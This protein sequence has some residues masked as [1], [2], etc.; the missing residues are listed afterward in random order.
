MPSTNRGAGPEDVKAFRWSEERRSEDPPEQ[1][2]RR[3]KPRECELHKAPARMMESEHRPRLYLQMV[4]RSNRFSK[5]KRPVVTGYQE[6]LAIVDDIPRCG[7][8]EGRGTPPQRGALF[9]KED[10][11]T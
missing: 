6:M 7:V 2:R 5:R 10:G 11:E 4:P 9:Q 8:G 1:M 3:R